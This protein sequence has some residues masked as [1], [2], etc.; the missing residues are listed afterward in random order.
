MKLLNKQPSKCGLAVGLSYTCD[1]K[2]F[3]WLDTVEGT[4]TGPST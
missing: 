4:R 1:I 3:E 2:G